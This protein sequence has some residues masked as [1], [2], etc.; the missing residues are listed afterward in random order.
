MCC[1]REENDVEGIRML[2]TLVGSL[3]KKAWMGANREKNS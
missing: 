1:K 3:H 2:K